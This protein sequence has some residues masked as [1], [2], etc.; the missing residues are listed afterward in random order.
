MNNHSPIPPPRW[1]W[2]LLRR[3]LKPNYWEELEGDMEEQFQDNV[4][5]HGLLRA[6]RR[7]IWGAM[8]LLRPALVKQLS[9]DVRLNQ[10]GMVQHYFKIGLR[11]LLR[12]KAF[13]LINIFGLAVAMSVCMLIILMLADQKSY[14]QFHV[15]KDH[16]Y[17]ILIQPEDHRQPYATTPG[18][19]AE[20]LRADF[21]I[22]SEVTSLR[23]GFGGDAVYGQN[24]AEIKG[25]F[26][27]PTFFK[28]FSY[29]L[30][31]GNP[32]SALSEPNTMVMTQ[33]IS[34]QLF[35][36]ENPIG[37]TIDFSD[38]GLDIFTEEGYAPVPWGTY[39]V[40]GVL[41]KQ[42]SKT[43]LSFEVLV[44]AS[45]LDRLYREDRIYDA[46]AEW[47]DYSQSYTY[48]RV[49]DQV[50]EAQLNSAL[51]HL[52]TIQYRDD[53]R[54]KSAVFKAQ[55][56]TK[57]TPGP[58][59]GNDPLIG[60]PMF[61]YY[62]LA[63]LA[64]VIMVSACLNYT[65]LSIA[66]ALTRSKEIGVRKA[67][68]AARRD[69]VFQFLG[70]SVVTAFLALLFAIGIL[71]LVRAGFLN[72]WVNQYLN[73][74]LQGNLVTLLI[75]IGFAFSI[76]VIAGIFPALRLSA[77]RP[78]RALKNQ[79]EGAGSK[80]GMRKLLT[81]VQFVISLFLIVTSILGFNQF[82]HFMQYEYNFDAHNVVSVNLQSNDYELVKSALQNVPGVAGISACAY[83]PGGGRNDGITLK[84]AGETEGAQVIDLSVD[85][86]FINT[87]DIRLI[88]GG[89]L[90]SDGRGAGKSILVSQEMM[91][92]FGYEQPADIIGES[93]ETAKGQSLKV[94]GV[95]EDF[96]FSLVFLRQIIRPV[97][98]RNEPE[99][100][101]FITLKVEGID[102][103]ATIAQL[104]EK[105]QT[106]DPIHP[107]KY[108][109]FDDKLTGNNKGIFDLVSVI[110]FFAFLAISIACLGLL[111]ITI[112]A[113]ERRTK[114]IGIRKVLGAD[115]FNLTYLLSREFLVLLG[116]SILIAA[117]ASYFIN[118][119]WLDYLIVRVDFGLGT[120]LLGSI[121]LFVLGLITI[122]PQT[123]RLSSTNPVQTLKDE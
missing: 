88:A 53:E 62:I 44:S 40:T 54:L 34:E 41:A 42:E 92:T 114:E 67:N 6:R 100:F 116:I 52:S 119:L 47:G 106:V 57:I 16:I 63:G 13:S 56:L 70:E 113:T 32:N 121:V 59:L 90:P 122:V 68:G 50:N 96:T 87:L 118:T 115:T 71:L 37:K 11:T 8:L 21:P 19:L 10:Y 85:E 35:G 103:Q 97:I 89:N 78:V 29:Q 101:H 75:F 12:H 22:I 69:L 31:K 120:V 81:I 107:F 5:K 73:L 24:Y 61:A 82:R 1:P 102:R 46:S 23:K 49:Q 43:H 3:V 48:V 105:W 33:R 28:V 98:L 109:F 76:G 39:T 91:K 51:Q 94:V 95:V 7:Y 55:A 108:E 79:H 58:V 4:Q 20:A 110:G 117:P 27:D 2:R 36:Q 25:Y 26:T 84:P 45:S 93:F 66:R 17:R 65:N 77:F 14:D 18:P 123:M 74:E 104:E 83:L 111:G 112:Y 30:E 99:K 80:L 15:N 9:G 38:R 60:L 72:L 64:F 86:G